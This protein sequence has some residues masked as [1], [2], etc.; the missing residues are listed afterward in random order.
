MKKP[1]KRPPSLKISIPQQPLKDRQQQLQPLQVLST[2]RASTTVSELP[3]SATNGRHSEESLSVTG[4]SLRKRTLPNIED[5]LAVSGNGETAME[6]ERTERRG[7]F[8][9]V[10]SGDDANGGLARNRSWT[11]PRMFSSKPPRLAYNRKNMKRPETSPMLTSSPMEENMMSKEE[12]NI[13][14]DSYIPK[15]AEHTKSWPYVMARNYFLLDYLKLF[16]TFLI[17]ILL[18][19]YEVKSLH[20]LNSVLKVHD[21]VYSLF[22]H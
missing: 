17:N 6:I 16:V 2:A 20:L 18:L 5:T 3:P 7:S 14:E 19:T 9:G 4:S 13:N 8:H 10:G 15:I 21:S 11:A 12:M 1:V 22:A